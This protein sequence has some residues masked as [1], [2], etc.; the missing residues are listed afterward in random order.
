MGTTCN[1]HPN[2]ENHFK[3]IIITDNLLFSGIDIA[4]HEIGHA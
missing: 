3:A 2:I 4:A 1:I